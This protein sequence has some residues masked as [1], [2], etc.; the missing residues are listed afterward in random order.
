[1]V[2]SNSTGPWTPT[3]SLVAA[4]TEN[5]AMVLCGS[6]GNWAAWS[7]GE[8]WI[9]CG[10]L[11]RRSNPV[12]RPFFTC[13]IRW[14]GSLFGGW[15]C[16]LQAVV[17]HPVSPT[18]WQPALLPTT[19]TSLQFYCACTVQIHLPYSVTYWLVTVA[20]EAVA[21]HTVYPFAQISL[22]ASVPCNEL[23][24]G[25]KAP[26]FCTPSLLDPCWASSLI[27][28]CWPVT[29]I[30]WLCFHRTSPFTHSRFLPTTNVI[31]S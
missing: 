16:K 2:S 6:T 28:C 26:G 13:R 11:L 18:G 25:F 29:D 22:H 5:I 14:L 7:L 27:F 15:L 1:M 31:E 3:G 12:N 23:L 24:V 9:D 21:C 30:L 19:L 17:H 8:A 4:P 10:G 20:L